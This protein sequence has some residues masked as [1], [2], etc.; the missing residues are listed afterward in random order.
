MAAATRG[1]PS[2]LDQASLDLNDGSKAVL[3]VIGDGS[4]VQ[5]ELPA[6]WN[7]ETL[8]R[9]VTK[10]GG[11][12]KMAFVSTSEDAPAKP[13]KATKT[14]AKTAPRK[15]AAKTAAKV[16]K[17]PAKKATTRRTRKSADKVA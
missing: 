12:T 7:L 3:R 17:A 6:Q 13:E 11:R 16:T 9:S 8:S 15:T 5:V 14:A 10:T 1:R 2:I 4:T